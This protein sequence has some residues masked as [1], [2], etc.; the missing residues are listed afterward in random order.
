MFDADASV[1]AT[2]VGWRKSFLWWLGLCAVV[3]VT[4]VLVRTA[5]LNVFY[6]A[7]DMRDPSWLAAVTWHNGWRLRGPPAN[8]FPYFHEHVAPI[9]WLSNAVSYV[10]PLGKF[11]YYAACIA[12]IH[13]LYAAG[14]YRAWLLREPSQNAHRMSIAALAALLA[15][16]SGVA[17]TALGMP[18]PE[19]AIPALALWFF[20]ALAQ[21]E[22]GAAAAWLGA[23]LAVR[24]D[25]GL[26][27]F[28]PLTLWIGVL[29]VRQRRID[30][31]LKWLAG[32]ALAALGYSMAAFLAK[33][34][35][36]PSA[37]NLTRVYLGSP[38]LHHVTMPFVLDRLSYYLR[39]RSFIW[40]PLLLSLVWSAISRNPLLPIG[41]VAALPWLALS[42]VSVSYPAG[43]LA[44]YYG[45]PF[46]LALAWPLIALHVWR[47]AD[48]RANRRWPYGLLLLVSIVGWQ[49][50]GP[51]IYPM[52][53]DFFGEV[54][55]VWHD[56]LRNRRY[57]DAFADYFLANRALFGAT[58]LDQAMSGLLVDQVDK[59]SWLELWPR[60]RPPETLIY[61]VNAFEFR[62]LVVPLLR[63]GIYDCVYGVPGTKIQL[64]TQQPL[65]PRLPVP[66]PF[67][68]VAA[69]LGAGC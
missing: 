63:S 37:D 13:A 33:R 17:V 35:Y 18:H 53:Q 5:V 36:F 40:L 51:A 47:R 69:A 34:L 66:R 22:H 21:R 15:A 9:L 41:Y 1:R 56:T 54:P 29:A 3:V 48:G 6:T 38:A 44:Y 10:V 65:S 57:D 50:G 16:F 43:T 61:F 4:F 23:C 12:V 19:L 49:R 39:E 20:I 31:D 14:I 24:E 67:L 55:F 52:A 2:N 11:D 26:H 68:V 8:P 32:F 7:G 45:F 60:D 30:R 64:A 27:V 46:W 59:T 28:V 58:A 25:A 42:F 62:P